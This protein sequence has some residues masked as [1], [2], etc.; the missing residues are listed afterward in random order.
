MTEVT[1]VPSQE[2]SMAHLI[3]KRFFKHRLAGYAIAVLAI[4]VLI[5]VFAFLSPYS[6]T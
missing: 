6:P 1:L 3:V 4:L 2:Q 5:S